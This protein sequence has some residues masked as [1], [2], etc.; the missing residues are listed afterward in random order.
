MYSLQRKHEGHAW[1][2]FKHRAIAVKITINF[3][4]PVENCGW[5]HLC[6]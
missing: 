1:C 4:L 6:C 3:L 5:W 2:T